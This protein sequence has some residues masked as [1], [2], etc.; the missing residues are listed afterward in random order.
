MAFQ[1]ENL[2]QISAGEGSADQTGGQKY[3]SYESLTDGV[4]FDAG[5]Q[6]APGYFDSLAKKVRIGTQFL[7]SY[8]GI[9]ELFKVTSPN[10]SGTIV[11][12]GAMAQPVPTPYYESLGAAP[13]SFVTAGGLS[14]VIPFADSVVGA[15]ANY[16][17]NTSVTDIGPPA[18]HSGIEHIECQAGQVEVFWSRAVLAGQTVKIWLQVLSQ[19]PSP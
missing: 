9:T 19:T 13:I 4:N 8:Q 7:L 3:L 1:P 14:D 5:G 12:L 6:L 17:L 2:I 10:P 11:E 18:A 15:Y 16:S